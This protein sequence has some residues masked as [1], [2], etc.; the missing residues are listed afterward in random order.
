MLFPLERMT[1]IRARPFARDGEFAIDLAAQAITRC[2]ALSRHQPADIDLLVCCNI[3]RYDAAESFSFEPS[4]STVLRERFGLSNAL[5][6]DIGNACTGVFTAINLIDALL[7]AGVIERAMV[8]S[9]EYITHLTGTAQKELKGFM[10]PRLACL[11]LGDAGVAMMLERS[12]DGKAGFQEIELYTLGKYAS[13]CI[14]KA[15]DRPHGGA[16]MLTDAIRQTAVGVQNAVAHSE[17]VLRRR[18]WPPESCRYLI[19]HQ[20]SE[21]AIRDAMRAINRLYGRAVCSDEN[22][23]I[24]LKDRGN[25]AT[26]THFVALD[27][28]IRGGRLSAGDRVLFGISGSG[29][30]IGTAV[31]DFDD[32]PERLRAGPEAA[33]P[34]PAAARRSIPRWKDRQRRA[35]VESIGTLGEGAPADRSALGMAVAAGRACLSRSRYELSEVELLL[36]AGVYRDEFL[37]EPAMA[38]MVAGELQMNHDIAS[39]EGRKTL[40]FDVFNGGVGFLD[41]C[42][43][44]SEALLAG[45]FSKAMVVAAEVENNRTVRP[46]ALLGLRET[47]SA[48]FLDVDSDG[49]TGFGRFLFRYRTDQLDAF[50]SQAKFEAGSPFLRFDRKPDL[51][52]QFLACIAEAVGELLEV[53][54]MKISD[55]AIF[56]PQLS[57]RFVNALA[58][59]LN[60]ARDHCIDVSGGGD[61]FTSSL[62]YAFANALE[63]GSVRTGDVGLAIAAGSGVQVGCAL[64]F[65]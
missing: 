15:T 39:P 59:R 10:D 11:T 7:R 19:M 23:I 46:D 34:R 16:I 65:F 56:P 43:V 33:A 44:A 32:L 4:T 63:R 12:S 41:A 14:A 25:T 52:E 35:R 48:L 50:S 62:P 2:L 3:S 58:A 38:S 24:N 20:T 45:K 26:T 42:W 18:D 53:E 47:A 8:V 21:T 22:T 36:Y 64:Y 29:Q 28:L 30:T 5:T 55:L 60:I 17:Y 31:Y 1:G 57:P 37:S 54:Q 61:L 6:F 51:E 27:D 49:A 9:G 13:L 40:A